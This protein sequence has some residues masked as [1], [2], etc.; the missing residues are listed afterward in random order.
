[1][2]YRSLRTAV[3][4]GTP[5]TAEIL[6]LDGVIY[7]VLIDDEPLRKRSRDAHPVQFPSAH[8]AGRALYQLGLREGVLRHHSPFDEMI[9]RGD[10]GPPP[11]PLRTPLRFSPA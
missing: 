8:A 11:A 10:D 3:A 7:L 1:M 2:D 5:P 9:G 6:S 4:Q